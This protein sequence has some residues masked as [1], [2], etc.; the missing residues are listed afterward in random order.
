MTFVATNHAILYNNGIPVF[1]DI[2]RDTLN[3]D[4]DEI[5]KNITPKT[6]AIMVVHY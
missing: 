6:K 2:E 1:T 4:P 3:I 5:E